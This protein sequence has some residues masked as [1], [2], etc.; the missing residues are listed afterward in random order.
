[1]VSEKDYEKE[2][3][4]KSGMW[5]KMKELGKRLE[6]YWD[7]KTRKIKENAPESIKKDYEL[8]LEMFDE[9]SEKI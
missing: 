6:P 4:A 8:F 5:K 9:L 2:E 1:M 3:K 7:K